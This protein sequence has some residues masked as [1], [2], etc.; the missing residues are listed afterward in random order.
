M[1][2]TVYSVVDTFLHG[3]ED[4]P[5]VLEQDL[6]KANQHLYNYQQSLKK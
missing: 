2:N 3:G 4:G 1:V 5:R 6:V